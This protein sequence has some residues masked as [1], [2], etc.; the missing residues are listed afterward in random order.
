M[1]PCVLGREGLK[2]AEIRP[3][4]LEPV[5]PR[6]EVWCSIQLSYGRIEEE[7]I[8]KGMNVSIGSRRDW[9]QRSKWRYC[10]GLIQRSIELIEVSY[11]ALEDRLKP[12]DVFGMDS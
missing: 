3:T 5:T 4:G 7:T 8:D 10:T 6:S 12:R 9:S 2:V 1:Q 11:A